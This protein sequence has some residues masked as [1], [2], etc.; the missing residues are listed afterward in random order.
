[1]VFLHDYQIFNENWFIDFLEFGNDFDICATRVIN[2][3]GSRYRDWILCWDAI[4]EFPNGLP[5]K[6]HILPYSEKRLSKFMYIN[7][8]YWIAKRSVMIEFP[9]DPELVWGQSEDIVWSKKVTKKYKFDI[10]KK[11]TLIM[12][13]HKDPFYNYMSDHTY[14]SYI[15]PFIEKNKL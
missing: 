2:A 15:L 8:S 1:M 9:L 12:L 4:P 13:K 6:E 11:S 5:N 10:N 7:G 14:N 3:D